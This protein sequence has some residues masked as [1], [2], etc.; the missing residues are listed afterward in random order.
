MFEALE[1]RHMTF[2]L[3][4]H[5]FQ[6]LGDGKTSNAVALGAKHEDKPQGLALA[7][8]EEETGSAELLSIF[9][10]HDYRNQGV[11]TRLMTVLEE[12]LRKR[13][14]RRLEVSFERGRPNRDVLEHILQ[15][16]GYE[17]PLFTGLMCRVTDGGIKLRQAP[18]LKEPMLPSSF[19][20]FLWK[21]L[22]EEDRKS[23]VSRQEERKW[24]PHSLSP[25]GYNY[26]IEYLNSLGLR[27]RG[28]VVG[29]IIN[30]R[31]FPDTI[32]YTTLFVREDL[33]PF[34]LSISL[35]IESMRHHVFGEESK[36]APRAVFKVPAGFAGM[37]RFAR[38]KM[39][40]YVDEVNELVKTG[41]ELA[42]DG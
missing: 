4:Q 27:H 33:Q 28:K 31:I 22:T 8:I 21:D 23:I 7:F 25:F 24:Y 42:E 29:W 18:W 2:P 13:G 9:T 14:I 16:L 35:L 6:L 36:R 34:G 17:T 10:S 11:A 12:A 5:L 30:H 3:Y 1:Y 20:I 38:K 41:K 15:N 19:E 37:I 32:R 40:P 39:A 26:Q